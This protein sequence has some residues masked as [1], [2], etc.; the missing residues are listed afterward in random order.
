MIRRQV[1]GDFFLDVFVYG[2]MTFM[3][4]VTLF[5]FLNVLSKSLSADWAVVSG[6]VSFF[7]VDF[8]LETMKLVVSSN[9]FLNAFLNSFYITVAGTLISLA[10]TAIT[11]YPLS[12]KEIKGMKLVLIFFVFTML[13]NGGLIP[14][15]MLIK[16][17]HLINNLWSVILPGVINVFN[18]LIVKSYYE[19]LPES[20]EESARI[21]GA[22]NIGILFKIIIPLSIPVQATIFLFIAVGYW[23][24]YFSPMLY[25]TRP[26]LKPLQVYMLDLVMNAEGS[27]DMLMRAD[28]MFNV[29]P[30]GVRAA[31]IIASTVPIILVYPFLQRYFIKGVL[32]GS[33]KG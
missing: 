14:N 30:E 21:D 16:E 3:G 33:V 24:E 12:K 5:P 20:L 10:V 11:A 18:L 26:D 13:F 15:Y 25:L 4:V 28:D 27:S 19:S 7:P 22:S 9:E 17:L 2:C 8:Q 32:I 29:S 6:K 23:N 1:N 31:T